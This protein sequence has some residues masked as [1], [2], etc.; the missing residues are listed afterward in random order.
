MTPLRRLGAAAV[1]GLETGET[2]LG[3]DLPNRPFKNFMDFT[4]F[5]DFKDFIHSNIEY[6]GWAGSL[7]IE[8]ARAVIEIWL[9]FIWASRAFRRNHPV[10]YAATPPREGNL[11]K[12]QR[13]SRRLAR[14]GRRD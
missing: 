10:G 2:S 13:A 7:Y 1:S 3:L 9:V 6:L 8:W 12:P 5:I 4:P 14:H 11:K